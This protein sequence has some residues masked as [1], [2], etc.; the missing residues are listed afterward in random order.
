VPKRQSVLD[1][2]QARRRAN[3]LQLADVVEITMRKFRK[4][5]VVHPFVLEPLLERTISHPKPGKIQKEEKVDGR[6]AA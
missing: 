5:K 4:D 6:T 3:Y 2:L 1:E